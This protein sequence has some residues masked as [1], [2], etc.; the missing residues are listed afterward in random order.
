MEPSGFGTTTRTGGARSAPAPR[1]CPSHLD[2]V[3]VPPRCETRPRASHSQQPGLTLFFFC[4]RASLAVR[5]GARTRVTCGPLQVAA[6]RQQRPSASAS[7]KTAGRGAQ[8][9]KNEHGLGVGDPFSR[10]WLRRYVERVALA[11]RSLFVHG[12]LPL[13]SV[14]PPLTA[15]LRHALLRVAHPAP[16]SAR[17]LGRHQT[18]PHFPSSLSCVSEYR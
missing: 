13:F 8:T 15:L 7:A 18:D 10:R 12:H 9:C 1:T 11:R 4:H 17:S 6:S 5:A 3:R 2:R 16:A 14:L